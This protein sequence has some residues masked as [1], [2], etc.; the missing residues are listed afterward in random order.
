MSSSA[1]A[2]AFN[3]LLSFSATPQ[4]STPSVPPA[5]SMVRIYDGASRV[6]QIPSSYAKGW[7]TWL[8]PH[9]ASALHR[10]PDSGA[11]AIPLVTEPGF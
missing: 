4:P 11:A 9:G 1:L 6:Q 3:A 7:P 2:V 5:R 8:L 10:V